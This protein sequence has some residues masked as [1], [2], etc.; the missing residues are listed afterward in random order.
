MALLPKLEAAIGG[1]RLPL[2]ANAGLAGMTLA[3]AL[4]VVVIVLRGAG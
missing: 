2:F 4:L 1:D 3:A